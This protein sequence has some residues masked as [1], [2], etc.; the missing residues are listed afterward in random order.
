MYCIVLNCIATQVSTFSP[1]RIH[2][3]TSLHIISHMS[4]NSAVLNKIALHYIALYCI[5]LY[6][7]LFH[8]IVWY[9]LWYLCGERRDSSQCIAQIPLGAV[10][11]ALRL[12]HGSLKA[13]S[14][15][16]R[17]LLTTRCGVNRMEGKGRRG[18]EGLG[19]K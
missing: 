4:L 9:F 2:D 10:S 14:R 19:V 18:E 15:S 13:V 12:Y 3:I 11:L 8:F 6:C 1:L 5:V 7:T 17:L 16:L